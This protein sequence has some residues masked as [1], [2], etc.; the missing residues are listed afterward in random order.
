MRNQ[1]LFNQAQ[2]EQERKIFEDN[3][4]KTSLDEEYKLKKKKEKAVDIVMVASVFIAGFAGCLLALDKL[5]F[6]L[7]INNLFKISTF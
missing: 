7:A 6:W 5:K 4:P 3:R 2:E 1:D